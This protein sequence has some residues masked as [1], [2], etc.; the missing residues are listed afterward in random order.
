MVTRREFLTGSAAAL[1]AGSFG[2]SAQTQFQAPP[3]GPPPMTRVKVID[4][5]AHWYPQEWLD[6]VEKEAVG[7]GATKVERNARGYLAVQIP[8][9]SVTFQPRYT[10]IPSRL[11]TM[12]AS[13]VA[14]H[15]MSLT[16]PMVYWAEPAFGLKLSQ[17]F[18]NAC[19]ALH[20]K[21][22]DRFIGLAMLPMQAP[23][24]AAEEAVRVAKLPGIR[25][26]YMST[27][28][29][30]ENLDEKKFWPVYEKCEALGLPI[31]LHPTNTLGAERMNKYHLRNF[32]G[33]PTESAIAAAS[34]MFGGVLDA[35]PKLDVVLPHSGGT[36]PILIG[37]WD[38]GATVRPEVKDLKSP[39]SHYLRRFHYDTI[40]HSTPILMNLVRQ[41]GADRVVCGTDFPADMALGDP[42]GTVEKLTELSTAERDLILR[43]NAARLLKIGA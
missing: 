3:A 31:F 7:Q 4:I 19:S 34:L 24:L 28:V 21:Q 18:N 38:H 17:A 43:G 20:V 26:V 29:L 12:D 30:G 37:R 9:L 35:Y 15:A 16:Q 1:C 14:M 39:P 36:F 40:A 41:V 25:G 10:E 11:K 33:N 2:A 27:H 6:L 22:P 42:V 13:G 32:I 8:G 5:H 23:E